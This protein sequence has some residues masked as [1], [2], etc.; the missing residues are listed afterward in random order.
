MSLATA[1]VEV[2]LSFPAALSPSF[3]LLKRTIPLAHRPPTRMGMNGES[4]GERV[5]DTA[6]MAGRARAAAQERWGRVK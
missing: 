5:G 3:S 2:V 1:R 4:L 6:R